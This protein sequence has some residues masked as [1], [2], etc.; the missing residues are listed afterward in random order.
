[1]FIRFISGE[2]DE[3]SLVSAGIFSAAFELLY[4][5][6]FPDDEYFALRDVMDWFNAHLKGPF[7]YQLKAAWRAPR[8][9]C[10]FKPTAHEYLSRAWEMAAILERND[11]FIRTIK[12]QRPG[13]VLYEDEA[14]IL[15]QPFADI[16]RIL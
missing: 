16:R 6:T 11:I 4:D 13:Y 14:Q 2:I 7:Q 10:W 1:M 15:A 5:P 9:I 3:D 8:A 12:V